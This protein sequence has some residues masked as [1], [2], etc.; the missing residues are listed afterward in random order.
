MADY[1]G[2]RKLNRF[3]ANMTTQL[4]IGYLA[5]GRR[6]PAGGA[7][8]PV[9]DREFIRPAIPRAVISWS[10]ADLQEMPVGAGDPA[11]AIDGPPSFLALPGPRSKRVAR[12]S[13]DAVMFGV[14]VVMLL[15]LAGAV[16][17]VGEQPNTAWA[18]RD[19]AALAAIGAGKIGVVEVRITRLDSTM[20]PV[21]EAKVASSA[22]PASAN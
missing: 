7:S 16:A 2:S 18:P 6:N 9:T 8:I 20:Q 3:G 5:A 4:A 11:A 10:D 22:K 19:P 15:G 13:M 1:S 12:L 21:D 14:L 17:K